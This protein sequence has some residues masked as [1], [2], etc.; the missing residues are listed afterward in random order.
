MN[1]VI[2]VSRQLG[3]RGSYIAT[4]VAKQLELRYI[5]REILQRAA[6]IA[7]Y[8]D[9]EMIQQLERQEQVPSRFERIMDALN[10]LPYVPAIPSATLR[11]GYFYDEHVAMLMIQE[12]LDRQEAQQRVL[13]EGRRAEASEAYADLVKKVILEYAHEGGVIIVGRGGQVILSDRPNV[14]HIQ[15]IAKKSLR[16]LW[17]MERLGIE[18]KEAENQIN[19]SDKARARYM[20]HFHDVDWLDPEYYHLIINSGKSSISWAAQLICEAARH[21]TRKTQS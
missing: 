1:I 8:P 15:V 17:L 9:S 16:V 13:E 10:T 7:G 11:E 18:S 6:E 19:Q 5:D 21:M 4:E 12:G 14:L 20:K 2:T 3:S